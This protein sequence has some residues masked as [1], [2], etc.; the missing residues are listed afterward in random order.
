MRVRAAGLVIGLAGILCFLG[1]PPSRAAEPD[2]ADTQEASVT[3]PVVLVEPDDLAA[4]APLSPPLITQSVT[5]P[6]Y[7]EPLPAP[8]AALD[9]E[10][11]ATLSEKAV[12]ATQPREAMLSPEPLGG[13]ES[14]GESIVVKPTEPP[15]AVPP[16]ESESE[17]PAPA[18]A[19]AAER[20]PALKDFIKSAVESPRAKEAKG[21]QAAEL[22]KERV[23]ISSFYAEHDYA[24]LWITDGKANA[25]A[26]AALAQLARAEDDGLE[27]RA[28][29]VP[30]F[31]GDE[32][33][34]AAAEV[35]L[36]AEVVAYGRQA[37]GSRVDPRLISALIGA[38]PELADPAA[39]LT[40]VAAAGDEAG[41][42]LKSFN[43]PQKAYEALR[44]KLAELRHVGVPTARVMIPAGPDLKVGMRDPRVSLIRARF[45]LDAESPANSEDL[46]YD[47]RV[48][49]AVADFQKA[50]GLPA[51]GVLSARTIAALSGGQPLRLENE[52]LA[53]MERWRWM[54]RDMGE[55]RVE[56]NIPE[57]MVSVIRTGEVVA[58]NKVVVGKTAT[59]TP[60]FS[61][62]MQF[63]IVNPSWN[64]PQS[65]IRKEMLP[66]LGQDPSYLE[67]LGYQVRRIHGLL[68]V[69][70][71]PGERNALG[72]IKFM[73]PNDYSVYLH[74]TP[75]RGLFGAAQR[76]F[77]HGCVRVDQPFAFAEAVLGRD[78]GWSAERVKRMIGGGERYV[79][80][81]K[82]LPIHIEYF[83]AFVDETG[84]LQLRD[85]LYGY[86]NRVKTA[87]GLAN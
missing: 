27:L 57:F 82:P 64:V 33:K 58:R 19:Q 34:L 66:R 1:L 38:K 62:T 79:Y 68:F 39:I 28:F 76:A 52:I 8:A 2:A 29:A 42:A 40:K 16:V 48:A 41:M 51:S 13:R 24:S 21:A 15:A 44:E 59:P 36:S 17:H 25:A 50:N 85:D 61:K 4:L 37:S 78:N 26:R 75:S 20:P 18:D 83:T 30:V 54:P 7:V 71:P 43:P 86:S 63:L 31:E 70:Q 87:L 3:P 56:V 11:T 6:A 67:R 81:P 14:L 23:A 74:D 53:N 10:S 55:S 69:R 45:G 35:A 60:V 32:E 49:A 9:S 65:I 12:P 47:T 73:F 5:L 46:V 77:S 84:R 72:R 22:S 80:L